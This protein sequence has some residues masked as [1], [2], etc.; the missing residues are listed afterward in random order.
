MADVWDERE[1]VFGV[2]DESEDEADNRPSP[3]TSRDNPPPRIVVT[4]SN[5]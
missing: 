4:G 2:G 3:L 1:E 5:S